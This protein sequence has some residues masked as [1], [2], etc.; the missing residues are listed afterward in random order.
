MLLIWMCHLTF[1]LVEPIL[2]LEDG[3]W[4]I[5]ELIHF[6]LWIS[7]YASE[8]PASTLKFVQLELP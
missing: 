5:M 1:S 7:D 8:N 6:P 3:K 4:I 2:Y